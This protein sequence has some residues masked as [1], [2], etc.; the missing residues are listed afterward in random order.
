M[1]KVICD[2][3]GTTYQDTAEKC[4]ICG[5]NQDGE[6][7]PLAEEE[8]LLEGP[9]A[10]DVDL[11]L[12]YDIFEEAL[13]LTAEPF[14]EAAEEPRQ[15]QTETLEEDEDDEESEPRS[16]TLLVV[17]LVVLITL[18]LTASGYLF[19]RY[20][21]PNLP[22]DGLEESPTVPT[23]STQTVVP[24]TTELKIPC[25]G[26]VL[27]GGVEPISMEGGYR[28]LHVRPIPAD[29]TEKLLFVSENES[30]VTVNDNGRMTATGQGETYV[31]VT[32]GNQKLRCHVVV[33]YSL[34]A[35]VTEPQEEIPPMANAAE[36]DEDGQQLKNVELKL[37]QTEFTLAVGLSYTIPLDCDLSYEEIQWTVEEP[38]VVK[39]ENGK[40][41]A[42]RTGITDVV[43]CYGDQVVECR[44][45]C[46]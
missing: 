39:V 46:Q 14:E 31:T 33:D 2:I 24:T 16:N 23:L 4:P 21:L 25:E 32:C 11:L 40:V 30:V 12:A 45:R 44:I 6:L 9:E 42:L 34:S 1:S 7:K 26:L 41:T 8:L 28:L 22:N 10:E 5:C 17:F 3:C 37:K 43:A 27:T 35:G 13:E 19:L 20:L 18:L 29:T 15:V 38:Q 36:A